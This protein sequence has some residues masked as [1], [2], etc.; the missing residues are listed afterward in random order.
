MLSD[1][2]GEKNSS[3][4][5]EIKNTKTSSDWSDS[6]KHVSTLCHPDCEVSVVFHHVTLH[7]IKHP[8]IIPDAC[9]CS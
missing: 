8:I 2:T 7:E 3:K 4:K 1:A 5:S 6:V 9:F